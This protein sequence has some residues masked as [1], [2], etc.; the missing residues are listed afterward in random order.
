MRESVVKMQRRW[1]TFRHW[2][3]DSRSLLE[4][5]RE[6]RSSSW[7]ARDLSSSSPAPIEEPEEEGEAAAPESAA[8]I[9]ASPASKRRR[10]APR[11]GALAALEGSLCSVLFRTVQHFDLDIV[12]KGDDDEADVTCLQGGGV[13]VDAENGFVLT[14]RGVVPQAMGDVEVVLGESSHSAFVWFTHPTHSLVVLKVLGLSGKFGESARF[15]ERALEAGEEI[16]FVGVGS[17]GK[18]MQSKVTVEACRLTAFPSHWPLRWHEQNLEAVTLVD[19]P[20]NAKGGVLSDEE[21]HI[22]ALF[23]IGSAQAEDGLETFGYCIPGHVLLPLLTHLKAQHAALAPLA[24]P[25]LEV[26]FCN[27]TLQKLRKLPPKIRPPAS[28]LKRLGAMGASCLKV[29]GITSAGPC[30]GVLQENDLLVAV[31]GEPVSSAQAIEAQLYAAM[32][33]EQGSEPLEVSLTLLRQGKELQ[34]KVRAPLLGSDCTRRFLVWHGL[35]LREVPR[36]LR[37]FGP[38]PSGLHIAQMM[39]GSPAEAS[40]IEGEILVGID[41]APVPN[42]DAVL[43]LERTRLDSM[44]A[45]TPSAP[46][47]LRLESVSVAGQRFLSTLE[48]D[49]L[50][51]PTFEIAQDSMG[52]WT[53]VEHAA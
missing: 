2:R 41:G 19:D 14:D 40:S 52:T 23:C 22:C 25:S 20:T 48:P 5:E 3:M 47:H 45:D 53:C 15:V 37:E 18:C 13:V 17:D 30:D 9:D 32:Q 44:S 7:R 29:K 11:S 1:Y 46:K 21:G 34:V 50:F 4:M 27:T 33:R 8:A 28:W 31:R 16:D 6:S 43:A 51:W 35:V 24:V 42:L 12:G 38:M 49:S 10:T 39:L 26:A 36:T